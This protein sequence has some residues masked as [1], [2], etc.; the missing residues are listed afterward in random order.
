MKPHEDET[1]AKLSPEHNDRVHGTPRHGWRHE[2]T[3]PGGGRQ[4]RDAPIVQEAEAR[5]PE[6]ALFEW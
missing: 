1:V 4:G 2:C 3:G 6:E 5:D